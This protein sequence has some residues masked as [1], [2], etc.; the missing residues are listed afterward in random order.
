MAIDRE[1][2]RTWLEATC[3]AQGLPVLVTDAEVV[4]RVGVLLSGRDSARGPRQGTRAE[5]RRSEP[6]SGYDPVRVEAACASRARAD[7]GEVEDSGD[8]GGLSVQVQGVPS[9][10]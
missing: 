5:S 10:P 4:A 1:M 8:N 2:L 6:P 9:F 3:A 7:R